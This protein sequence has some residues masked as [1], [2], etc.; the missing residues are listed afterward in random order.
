MRVRLGLLFLVAAK[1]RGGLARFQGHFQHFVHG[2]DEL[3]LEIVPDEVGRTTS[4]FFP[5]AF[6][7]TSSVDGIVQRSSGA[8]AWSSLRSGAGT[9]A[10]HARSTGL[11]PPVFARATTYRSWTSPQA[12]R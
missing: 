3:E 8:E 5:D 4:T 10:T 12:V 6:P 1:I 7:Q 9:R 11:S 2:L